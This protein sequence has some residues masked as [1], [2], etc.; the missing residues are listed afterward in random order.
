MKKS[1]MFAALAA[2]LLG[3]KPQPIVTSLPATQ[4]SATAD[5]R[6][7]EL[8]MAVDSLRKLAGGV[9]AESLKRTFFYFNQWIA[10]YE[11]AKA[12]WQPDKLIDR[13]PQALKG[14]PGLERLA[15]NRFEKED[16]SPLLATMKDD[17]P[18]QLSP[19]SLAFM[20]TLQDDNLWLN[21]LA[22]LQ[23]T[24]WL[25]DIAQRVSRQPSPPHLKP[26]LKEMETSLGLPEAEQL[27]AAERMFDWTI[28]NIQLDVLPPPPPP[29][30]ATVDS[31]GQETRPV[32]PALRGEVGP[33]YGQ[34][35]VQTLLY[36]HGDAHERA[37]IF[38]QLCR[39][40]GIDALMLGLED[41]N[42]PT[43]RPWIPAALIG[44]KLF[45][46]DTELGVPVPGPEGKGIAT[47][48]QVLAD[49]GVLKQLDVEG[50]AYPI[51]EKDITFMHGL[52]DAEPA[53][54]S[55]RMLL[56]QAALPRQSRL[57]LSVQPNQLET[58]LAKVKKIDRVS[59]WRVPFDAVLYQIGQFQKLQRDDVAWREYSR[60][61]NVFH[62]ARPLSQARNMHLQGRL[63]DVEKEA[64]ARTLYLNC[65]QPSREIDALE[66]S[67]FF[68]ASVGL[69]INP[70]AKPDEKKQAEEMIAS[71][72][73]L[74]RTQKQH[75][76]YWLGLSYYEEGNLNTTLSFLGKH[77]ISVSPPSPWEG[78][79]RYN[80]A[81][82]YEDLGELALARQWLQSDK[83]SPQQVGNQLRAKWLAQ[84]QPEAAAKSTE[85]ASSTP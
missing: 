14:T 54:L 60:H 33:G 2:L 6:S 85:T 53:A 10:S 19:G 32:S 26:W 23:Q 43:P 34:L 35:P 44:G 51:G 83:S 18:L 49:P 72:A 11:P 3:C 61:Q 79:A 81:R 25:H 28:R 4:N 74:A 9:S 62:P 5:H 1:F 50:H 71:M 17:P 20:Q 12:S 30:V 8:P 63:V 45:L 42:S 38:I 80:L 15:K 57:I 46:F 47:L 82:C 36:G 70:E 59:L 16:L 84:K 39:Q 76:T 77:T 13:L 22:Y 69:G 41:R 40:A 64:G 66:N 58:K 27:A 24:L 75:A 31:N 7:E 68:R 21:D 29:P 37:R 52:I 56:L 73:A 55:R 48:E 78:G 65:R 67:P